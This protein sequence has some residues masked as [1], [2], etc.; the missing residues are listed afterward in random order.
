MGSRIH[1][2][3]APPPVRR[4]A[5]MHVRVFL[6]CFVLVLMCVAITLWREVLGRNQGRLD[7]VQNHMRCHI[8]PK[9]L[10]GD[11]A[12]CQEPEQIPAQ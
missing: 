10:V 2:E 8:E 9:P 11:W 1:F 6:A 12:V 5:E 4:R 7:V 3:G